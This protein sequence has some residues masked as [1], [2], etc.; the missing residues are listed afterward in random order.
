MGREATLAVLAAG[1]WGWRRFG[2]SAARGAKRCRARRRRGQADGR[3]MRARMGCPAAS[4]GCSG[5]LSTSTRQR[6]PSSR[7]CRGSARSWRSGSW[8][9]GKRMGRSR[10]SSRSRGCRESGRGSSGC[11]LAG[12][13]RGRRARRQ[14]GLYFA[15]RG[16]CG[17]EGFRKRSPCKSAASV[18]PPR[19]CSTTR[20]SPRRAR[21][22]SARAAAW[23]SPP[24]RPWLARRPP[25]RRSARA[26]RSSA[27]ARPRRSP[28]PARPTRPSSSARARRPWRPAPARRRCSARSA[29]TRRRSPKP[30][31]LR[32]RKCSGRSAA[33][34]P[35]RTRRSCSERAASRPWPIPARP[36]AARR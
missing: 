30:I 32:P 22:C 34:S 11:W 19:T 5:C 15:R 18:A 13:P 16:P 12:R 35:A 8:P 17:R 6:R 9:S 10:M 23:S 3:A 28:R 20:S 33:R 31:P 14:S 26:P 2:S 7:L 4:G 1:W 27:P 21:P 24:N 29:A 25:L 36:R